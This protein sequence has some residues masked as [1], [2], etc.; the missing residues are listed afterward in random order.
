MVARQLRIALLIEVA[1]YGLLGLWLARQ[2][3]SVAE[4][5]WLA[6]GL[7]LGIRAVVVAVTYGFMLADSS[8]V[9]VSLRIGALAFLRMMLVEY[10]GLILLFVIIQPFERWWLRPDCLWRSPDRLPILLIHGYQCNRGAWFR[11]RPRLEAAG[12]VVATLSLEPSLADI[13]SYAEGV[14]RR[15]DE[16]L[17]ATGAAQVILVCHSMGG[18]VAR[19]YLRRFGSARVGRL[20]TLAS[21]HHGSRL[22]ALAW[23]RNGRQMRIGNPWLADLGRAPLPPGTVS[24]YSVHDNQVM[25]QHTCSELAGARNVPLPGISHL[26]MLLAEPVAAALLAELDAPVR[27]EFPASSG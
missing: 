4:A 1:V 12:W 25:P 22:A 17:T 24:F 9:P 23:G 26:G 27:S 16:V 6:L 18:L 7:F 19:T 14:A 13:D 10:A 2:G 20:I 3:Q 11:L 5:A 21:P 15:I 8:P